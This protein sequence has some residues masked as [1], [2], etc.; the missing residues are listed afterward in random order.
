MEYNFRNIEQAA[1]QFWNEQ[2]VYKV[3]NTSDKPKYYVLDM[4]PY[5]SGAGLHVGH[6]LGY[7]ASDIFSRY[8]VMKGF[9]VLHPMGFDAFGLPAEQYAL[10]TGQHPV[11]TTEK[12]IARYK[13]QLDNIGFNYDWSR[14]VRTS[15]AKYYK[16]TQWIFLQ[17]FQSWFNRLTQKAEPLDK[18]IA[19]FEQEGN[20]QH[21]APGADDLGFTAEEW[22]VKTEEEQ[23]AILMH[24]RLAYLDHAVVWWCEALGTVLANDEVVNGVSERGGHPVEKKKMRQWFLRI[25]EFADRMIDSLN[26]LEWSEAMKEMQRNW[27]GRSEGAELTFNLDRGG[28]VTVFTTR[29]DTIFGVDFMVLA[30]EH[31]LVE[32]ITTPEQKEAVDQYVTYVKS[33]S[34]RERMSEKKISGCFTGAYAIHPFSD[35]QIPVWISEY[36]LAGYGT[37]AIMA[38]PAGDDRDHAFA[39]HFDI[40][41]TNIFGDLYNG[42]TAVSDKNVAISD[43]DFISGLGV[44]DAAAKVLDA[45]DEKNIGA[46]KINYKLRD[47]GFS[48]QRY[49]GEPFP[50]VY[51]NNVPYAINEKGANLPEALQQLPLEL[52]HVEN[53][54]PGPEGEGPLANVTDWVYVKD[55][56]GETLKRETNTMPGYAGSSWYF[57]RYMDPNN[58][59]TFADKNTTDY[60]NQVDLYIGGTEHAVGHLLYSRMWTKA[61]Y[62]LG[63]LSFDEPF[64]R[65]VNQGMIQGSTRYVYR[66]NGTNT[67]VS[68]GLKGDH[69]IDQIRVDVNFVNGVELDTE[70]FKKWRPEYN[71]AEFILENGKYICGSETEKMSKSK[72]NV[73]NPDDIVNQYGADTFRMYE[74]FLGPIEMSKPWDTKGIEG[75]HRFL[76]KFWRLFNDEQKGWIV[77]DEKAT[78]A[79]LKTLHKTIKK[80]EGDT[81]KFSFNTAVSQFMICVND[82]TDQNC[83]KREILEPLVRIITPY[84]PHIAEELW[85]QFGNEGSVI[86]AAYP[87]WDEKYT[88][89]NSKL[90]PIAV[91]GKARTEL[92]FALDAEQAFIEKEV[93][94][95]AVIQKW[96]EGKEPKKFIYVPGRM[97]NVVI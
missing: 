33:R 64:K 13:E 45:M 60:W 55:N 92:E 46:R 79:E 44:K 47:A 10:E 69:L 59:A 57:L 51:R 93:L 41:I 40:H 23:R 4:F 84:A 12:N 97:I 38:V 78:D 52:P 74:M 18:L 50:I 36:V 29:P 70:A 95:N 2:Q 6:P 28:A 21:A 88:T 43:S 94:S 89:E 20:K 81:E 42:E 5:P 14:E 30:P 53:Y 65:L 76:K 22:K 32:S 15:D 90:Y 87:Q 49:W 58:D 63:Y 35:K 71:D 37:G 19:L 86:H 16:W 8:K 56:N 7:I 67:F 85:K 77:T 34:E 80:I 68:L 61:L 54:K 83:H 39:K 72:Y 24:Y 48:R 26:N 25:T 66:I 9:N 11:V 75:V 17:L 27:I 96:L 82:L 3:N 62:D 73:V 1:K 91:N 31:E